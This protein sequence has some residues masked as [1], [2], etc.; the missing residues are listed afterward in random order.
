MAIIKYVV[1][2]IHPAEGRIL[3]RRK[4]KSKNRA[5]LFA[6]RRKREEEINYKIWK[7]SR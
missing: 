2:L 5:K 4:F 3:E 7:T 6:K 1:D